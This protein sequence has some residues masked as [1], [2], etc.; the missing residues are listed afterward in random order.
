MARLHPSLP[1]AAVI[2]LLLAIEAAWLVTTRRVPEGAVLVTLTPSHGI[3]AKDVVGLA[4]M[5]LALAVVA[6]ALLFW[7]RVLRRKALRRRAA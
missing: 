4:L 5:V 2:A 7:R 1:L 6:Q 3:T